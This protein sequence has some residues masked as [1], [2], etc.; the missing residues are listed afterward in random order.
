MFSAT[1]IVFIQRTVNNAL[2]KHSRHTVKIKY[3]LF[4]YKLAEK[5]CQFVSAAFLAHPK[6]QHVQYL[7]TR[8][9]L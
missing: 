8:N 1:I 6:L 7:R 4:C 3:F 5:N 9:F 2:I